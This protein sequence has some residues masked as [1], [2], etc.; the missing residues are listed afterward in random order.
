MPWRRVLLL[1]LLTV[2]PG[3]AAQAS[4]V[5]AEQ[6]LSSEAG[7]SAYAAGRFINALRISRPLAET[8]DPHAAYGL[9]LLYDLGQ[10][11][12]QDAAAAFL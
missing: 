10:G 9:G 1:A 6:S 3:L 5:S 8:G 12:A 11:V 2:L 4:E 7:E